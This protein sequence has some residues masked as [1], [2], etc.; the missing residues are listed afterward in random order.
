MWFSHGVHQIHLKS[1]QSLSTPYEVTE[2]QTNKLL[3][4][5]S[6][7]VFICRIKPKRTEQIVYTQIRRLKMRRLIRV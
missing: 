7:Q 2:P 3:T 4:R 1:R 6:H 5:Q